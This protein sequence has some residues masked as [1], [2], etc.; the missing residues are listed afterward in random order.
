[1]ISDT[2]QFGILC[3][4]FGLIVGMLIG[5]TLRKDMAESA[6]IEHGA[7]HY[8]SKTAKFTWNNEVKR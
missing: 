5:V 6:A 7:A 8:D 2:A 1:M 4:T 3:A